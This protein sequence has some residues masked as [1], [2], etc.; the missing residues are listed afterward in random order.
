[1]RSQGTLAVLVLVGVG[2]FAGPAAAGK[3]DVNKEIW[4]LLSDGKNEAVKNTYDGLVS[5]KGRLAKLSAS[6]NTSFY[7]ANQTVRGKLITRFEEAIGNQQDAFDDFLKDVVGAR[8]DDCAIC[9]YLPAWKSVS[10]AGYPKVTGKEL[11]AFS[12][13]QITQINAYV[14][15]RNICRKNAR[16]DE[17]KEEC[18]RDMKKLFKNALGNKFIEDYTDNDGYPGGQEFK[19]KMEGAKAEDCPVSKTPQVRSKDAS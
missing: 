15:T 18:D 8:S 11:S 4:S 9:R 1:M 2:A 5:V 16:D 17:G 7:P 14:E 6:G 19:T 10:A 3:C 12:S 13:Q